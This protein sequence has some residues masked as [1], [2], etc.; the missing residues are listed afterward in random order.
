MPNYLCPSCVAAKKAVAGTKLFMR[1]RGLH[2]K[3]L[4]A[5]KPCWGKDARRATVEA[6]T[7]FSYKKP[8]SVV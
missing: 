4:Y 2:L 7:T 3:Y 8:A 1:P 5:C 6:P